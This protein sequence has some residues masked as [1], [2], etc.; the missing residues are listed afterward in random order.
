MGE[1]W[2]VNDFEQFLDK[3]KSGIV[4]ESYLLRSSSYPSGKISHSLCWIP[5]TLYNYTPSS[6]E[7]FPAHEGYALSLHSAL[8]SSKSQHVLHYITSV[9]LFGRPL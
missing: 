9:H 5:T 2:W 6:K 1:E 8:T 3:A 7:D 4:P